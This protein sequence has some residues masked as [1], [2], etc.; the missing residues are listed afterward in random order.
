MNTQTVAKPWYKETWFWLL[1]SPM[2]TLIVTIPIMITTAFKGADDRVLD[3]YYKEGRMIN[4]RFEELALAVEL[5]IGGL[6]KLDWQT[7]ELWFESNQALEGASIQ[8]D[9]SHPAR[10]D[11]DFSLPLK[12]VDATRFRADL[13]V[14]QKGRWYFVLQGTRPDHAM[15][16][17]S[18]TSPVASPGTPQL[19]ADQTPQNKQKA[20]V[21]RIAGEVNL[22]DAK[23]G[24]STIPLKAYAH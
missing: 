24:L 11:L 12:A 21:W 4:H 3:N 19:Q 2:L 1:I 5:N 22:A 17:A 23:E 7:G 13:S 18:V 6:L 15:A 8:V 14:M 20:N 16:Q 9:F 10:A